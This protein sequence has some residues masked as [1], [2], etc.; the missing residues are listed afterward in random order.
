MVPELLP[1]GNSV[2]LHSVVSPEARTQTKE[3]RTSVL[4]T[5]T[6]AKPWERTWPRKQLWY[7]FLPHEF[8]SFTYKLKTKEECHTYTHTHTHTHTKRRKLDM[9]NTKQPLL[10][11]TV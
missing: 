6:K 8:L 2:S 7:C 10:Y 3:Y 1:P 4:M 11:L 5:Q 9:K